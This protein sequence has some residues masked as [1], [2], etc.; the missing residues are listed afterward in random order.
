MSLPFGEMS[1]MSDMLVVLVDIFGGIWVV[2][3]A[4]VVGEVRRTLYVGAT[5]EA[6]KVVMFVAVY[7]TLVHYDITDGDGR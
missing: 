7:F 3:V 6:T 2:L 4:C 5:T 1:E